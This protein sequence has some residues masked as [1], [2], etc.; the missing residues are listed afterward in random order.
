MTALFH[1]IFVHYTTPDSFCQGVFENYFEICDFFGN[2]VYPIK[3]IEK[4]KT[5]SEKEALYGREDRKARKNNR[6]DD[7]GEPGKI[8]ANID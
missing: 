8:K 7:Y 6:H 5:E 3:N 1:K 2:W 4:K